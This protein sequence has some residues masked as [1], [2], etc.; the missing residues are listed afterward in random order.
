MYEFR[1]RDL[2]GDWEGLMEGERGIY[3]A[4]GGEIPARTGNMRS[5]RA[6]RV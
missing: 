4:P 2:A 1:K 5:G 6:K 3:E